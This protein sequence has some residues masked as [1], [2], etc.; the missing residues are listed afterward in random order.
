MT[1]APRL[2]ACRR[3]HGFT[4]IEMMITVVVIAILAAVALPGYQNYVKRSSR[5][6]AQAELVELAGVQE[7]I[8]LNSNAYT[9]KVSAA[10]NGSSAG[11]L[12]A[13]TGKTRDGRYTLTVAVNGASYTITAT[14]VSGSTQAG[15]GNLTISSDGS[16]TWGSK[17]W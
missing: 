8:Y 2:A 9:D 6:A 13:S 14:P 17:T 11:G 16:R 12:G 3:A 4:L 15:D 1:P 7:K 10:Y 5:E